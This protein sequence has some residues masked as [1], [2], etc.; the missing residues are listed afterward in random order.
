MP[1]RGR[2]RSEAVWGHGAAAAARDRHGVE[3]RDA[4][5]P[6]VGQDA[7]LGRHPR[8]PAT[9][10]TTSTAAPSLPP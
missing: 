3:Q 9:A 8:A 4:V 5:L 1:R 6:V 2:Y 7:T 10:S